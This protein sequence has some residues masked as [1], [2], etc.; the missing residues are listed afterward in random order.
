MV[1]LT[2]LREPPP[3][4]A[5][6]SQ[7]ASNLR[8]SA[9]WYP[10]VPTPTLCLNDEAFPSGKTFQSEYKPLFWCHF[11]GPGGRNLAHLTNIAVT[12]SDDLR[13]IDFSFDTEVPREHRSFGRR[14]KSFWETTDFPIDGP[15]GERIS[16]IEMRHQFLE[17]QEAFAW[18]AQ[19]GFTFWCK[20]FLSA[21]PCLAPS[22]YC[23][24]SPPRVSFPL[25][26]H[27]PREI[28]PPF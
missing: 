13:G 10:D 3:S 14:K 6:A 12:R 9:V 28:V 11:G 21:S 17:A 16:S 20:V 18:M 2:L 15:G 1:Q 23:H 5:D 8:N 24:Y 4:A 7:P 19:D 25:A 22:A 26:L 27:K